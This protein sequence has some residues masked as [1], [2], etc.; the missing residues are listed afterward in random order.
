MGLGPLL[1]AVLAAGGS[2]EGTV[3]TVHGEALPGA[4]VAVFNAAGMRLTT[5]ASDGT[6]R[7]TDLERRADGFFVKLSYLFR[8]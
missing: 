4:T 5:T 3:M 1:A 7:F 8:A 2:V 6:F